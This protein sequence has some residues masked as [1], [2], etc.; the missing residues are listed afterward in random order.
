[1]SSSAWRLR[2]AK[3]KGTEMSRAPGPLGQS[4]ANVAI[5]SGTLA[6]VRSPSPGPTGSGIGPISIYIR[7]QIT[8]RY[9]V[10]ML[11]TELR[12]QG[13]A[14]L[15]PSAVGAMAAIFVVSVGAQFTP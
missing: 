13:Q 2:A 1:M 3:H 8:L 11:P 4:C 9:A 6:R 12:E 5:D 10:A 7:M 15:T 14:L